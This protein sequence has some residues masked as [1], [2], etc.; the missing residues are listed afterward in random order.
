M[1][2]FIGSTN[3]LGSICAPRSAGLIY[4]S[5][6]ITILSTIIFGSGVLGQ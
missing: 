3:T 5:Y 6:C 1:L 2:D 4:V